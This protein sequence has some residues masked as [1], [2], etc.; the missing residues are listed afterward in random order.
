MSTIT[1]KRPDRKKKKS[2]F[3]AKVNELFEIMETTPDWEQY[4]TKK[5]SEICKKLYDN[6]SM[7]ETMEY[8]DMKYITVRAHLLRAIERISDKR[9]DFKREGKSDQAQELF[10]L[11][12]SVENWKEYVTDNEANMAEEYRKVR[13][14]YRL[15]ESLGVAPG[16]IA[17]TLYGTTQ[18]MGVITK[19]KAGVPQSDRRD[20]DNR[21]NE[22]V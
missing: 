3:G 1:E 11:M 16:N 12:D 15:S 5:T 2:P 20:V 13:N 6:Q 21:R 7:N 4:V 10:E 14:F 8:F 19:I 22:E 18:K 9:T 17:G